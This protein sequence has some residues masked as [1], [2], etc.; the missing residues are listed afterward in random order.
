M[1]AEIKKKWVEALRSGEYEQ[2][3]DDLRTEDGS[4]C[5]LGVLCDLHSK[6]SGQLWQD[7]IYRT[8]FSYLDSSTYSPYEVNQWA[9]LKAKE[10]LK[11]AEMNDAGAPFDEIADYIEMKL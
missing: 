4:Y 10:S 2:G 9:G 5:C 8:G 3:R 7:A 1:K 6:E 11:L